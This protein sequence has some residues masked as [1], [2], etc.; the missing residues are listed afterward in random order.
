MKS[1]FLA[2]SLSICFLAACSGPKYVEKSAPASASFPTKNW[3]PV[4]ENLYAYRFE[5]D[6][7]GFKEFLADQQSDCRPDSTA[8]LSL[9]GFYDPFV[10]NYFIHPAFN[11]YP[12]LNISHQCAQAYCDWLTERFHEMAKRPFKQVVFRLPTESEWE[13]AAQ[14]GNAE[15]VFPWEAQGSSWLSSPLQDKKGRY[16]AN[17]LNINQIAIVSIDSD[18]SLKLSP[19]VVQLQKAGHDMYT[20]MA[21]VKSF[22]ANPIG[23]YNMAGNV[24]EM[25]QKPGISKGGSWYQTAYHLQ[26]N[27]SDLYEGPSPMLGF[28]PFMEV[29]E[30]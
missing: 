25:V 29:L 6:N 20:F 4:S 24:A 26:I 11:N 14:G 30:Q 27:S 28:R 10:E 17:F 16:Q 5:M 7:I 1:F 21:P 8:F 9:R 18:S 15:A 3:V 23:L 12:V 2:L 22:K 19:E 13:S